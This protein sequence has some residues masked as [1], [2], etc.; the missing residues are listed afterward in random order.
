MFNEELLHELDVR[1]KAHMKYYRDD[2]LRHDR[3][4][5]ALSNP[6]DKFIVGFHK[7]GSA[8]LFISGR[9]KQYTNWD[10]FRASFLCNDKIWYCLYDGARIQPINDTVVERTIKQVRES[11]P[12]EYVEDCDRRLKER[13]KNFSEEPRELTENEWKNLQLKERGL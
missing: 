1:A 4:R 13:W 5:V 11:F 6:H 9:Y 7:T 3:P 10:Y 12:E 8:I 2:W